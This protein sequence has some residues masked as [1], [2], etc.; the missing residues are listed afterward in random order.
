MVSGDTTNL[1]NFYE[2]D[3]MKEQS[4]FRSNQ[5][6]IRNNSPN[7]QNNSFVNNSYWS[8]E[9]VLLGMVL[10]IIYD[11]LDLAGGTFFF[12]LGG[13]PLIPYE[14]I[15]FII[16]FFFQKWYS[17]LMGPFYNPITNLELIPGLDDI[18]PTY[19]FASIFSYLKYRRSLNGYNSGPNKSRININLNTKQT[20]KF[21][22]IFV[23]CLTISLV[24]FMTTD[25][26]PKT[27]KSIGSGANKF[28]MEETMDDLSGVLFDFNKKIKQRFNKQVN[29]ALGNTDEF[30]GVVNLKEK[31]GLKLELSNNEKTILKGNS[32]IIYSLLSG[33][34]FNS[35]ACNLAG[36]DCKNS[37]ISLYC[38]EKW[39][40]NNGEIDP[41][42]VLF[43]E[44]DG[45]Y[46]NVICSFEPNQLELAYKKNYT[47]IYETMVY[48]FITAGY[49]KLDFVYAKK[50]REL[51]L[52]QG[53][54]F[55]RHL[56]IYTSGPVK[57]SFT[58]A[59]YY[60]ILVGDKQRYH[61]Q[62]QLENLG[63]GI[64]KSF[65]K[66]FFT[67]PEGSRLEL[68]DVPVID[69][70]NNAYELDPK[71]FKLKKY[72]KISSGS[73]IDV[74]CSID[75][76]S[77]ELLTVGTDYITNS[78]KVITSYKYGESHDIRIHFDD[79]DELVKLDSCDTIC[80]SNSGC[81]CVGACFT[82][83]YI[84]KGESCGAHEKEVK[85]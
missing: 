49:Q 29:M 4:D 30:E 19:T 82:N 70:G 67:I 60:P 68:C 63:G 36:I 84:S 40:H 81:E 9:N 74:S 25:I 6:P 64:I 48:D 15:E 41:K 35:E 21:V 16:N 8:Q 58:Q 42:E 79:S 56:P 11:F 77:P 24:L 31:L 51:E 46:L 75:L 13:L 73:S 57:V 76:S 5:N 45:S 32:L 37:K 52:K 10:A 78:F 17:K 50:L 38:S 28:S 39:S 43:D 3:N 26:F 71:L 47:T 14:I 12:E 83:F 27:I 80:K 65:N 1:G 20:K 53:L 44:I 72:Q 23:L 85:G 22:Y 66:I 54:K 33:K 55:K 18:L 34:G 62:F 59:Q 61:F 69:L 2:T 7:Y